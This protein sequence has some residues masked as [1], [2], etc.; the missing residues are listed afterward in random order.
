MPTP[1]V[2]RLLYFLGNTITAFRFPTIK[3]SF[4][5]REMTKQTS[6]SNDMSFAW[7]CRSTAAV[8]SFVVAANCLIKAFA[9]LLGHPVDCCN[10]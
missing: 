4:L 2:Y 1:T 3:E 5:N 7:T 9:L 6:S 8:P 10:L